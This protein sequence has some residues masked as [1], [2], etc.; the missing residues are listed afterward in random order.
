MNDE[1]YANMLITQ[2]KN[3]SKP[4]IHAYLSWLYNQIESALIVEYILEVGAGTGLSK[5]VF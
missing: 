4:G 2:A 5:H 1:D 3:S